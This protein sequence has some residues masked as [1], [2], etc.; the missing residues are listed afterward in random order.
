MLQLSVKNN[1]EHAAAEANIS[2]Q[3]QQLAQEIV[4]EISDY[5]AARRTEILGAFV[6]ELY[7][8]AADQH[9][10]EERSRHQQACVDAAKARGVRFGRTRKPLP[11]N[12]AECYEAWQNGE[13]TQSQAAESCGISRTAFY[14][15]VTRMRQEEV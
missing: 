6:S 12:F 1:Q 14:R 7:F 4:S 10:R 2:E 8:A 9:R 11:D 13:M 15:E 5:D 3:L